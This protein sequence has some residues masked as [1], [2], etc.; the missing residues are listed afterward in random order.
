MSGHSKWHTI[1]HKKAAADAKRGRVFTQLIKEITVAAR[2]GGGDPEGNPRLRTVLGAARAAN[3]PKDNIEKA[4]KKGTGE[5][6]GVDY[7][8]VSYEGYGPGGVALFVMAVTDNRNRTLPEIRHLFSKY[9]GNLGESNCV[10]WMFEKKGYLVVP[11]E[12]SAEETLLEVVLEAGG[13]DVREDGDNWEI[14]TP[15]DRLETVKDGI[16]ARG[17]PVTSAEI[18]MVPK[19]LVKVQGRQAQQLLSMMEA[20]EEHED[21]QNVWANFDMDESE[22]TEQRAAS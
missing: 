22:I 15:P 19:T 9:G 10:S 12:K 16:A 13:D 5:L 17:I 2:I 11:K 1:K 20:I 18:S 21:V 7:E 4:I 14:L 8:E 6:P 3:M